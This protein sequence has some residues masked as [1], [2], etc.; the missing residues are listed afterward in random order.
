MSQ[1][2]APEIPWMRIFVEGAVIVGSIL[3]AFGIDAW[4]EDVGARERDCDYLM[5]LR[6]E[7]GETLAYAEE[8]RE[9]RDLAARG[10]ASL[11]GQ[12]QGNQRADTD[13]L[14]SWFSLTSMPIS[15]SPPISV[16]NDVAA[17]GA[18]QRIRQNDLR[19]ALVQY[20]LLLD[21]LREQDE[22]ASAVSEL[23]LQPFLEGRIP[24]VERLRRGLFGSTNEYEFPFGPSPHPVDFNAVFDKPELEDML[25]ER[26]FRLIMGSVDLADVEAHLVEVISLI[27]LE[28]TEAE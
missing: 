9:L 3:L 18:I 8:Q 7:F 17:S 16:F 26:W 24:R 21:R 28:L 2:G 15:F 22:A 5:S 12:V 27:D 11:I 20:P 14:Y 13:S 23:R 1:E 25:A 4:W 6:E 19:I 10:S